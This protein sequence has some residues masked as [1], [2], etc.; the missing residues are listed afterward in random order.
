MRHESC[1][2]ARY[3]RNVRYSDLQRISNP[4]VCRQGRQ[5]LHPNSIHSQGEAPGDMAVA[6]PSGEV[7]I[8]GRVAG[9]ELHVPTIW[10]SCKSLEDGA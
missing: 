3:G 10:N 9:S 6:A 4:S 7:C 5:R 8:D 1:P 2:V